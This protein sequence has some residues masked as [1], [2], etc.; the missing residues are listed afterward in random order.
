MKN[1]YRST[2]AAF[3]LA[4]LLICGGC[5][6]S[7]TT[8]TGTAPTPAP[9]TVANAISLLATADQAAVTTAITARDAG[10]ISAADCGAIENV[11]VKIANAGLAMNAELR[12]ADSWSVQKQKLLTILQATGLQ[13]L[14][15]HIS[16]GAYLVVVDLITAFN[17][18]S[19]ALGGPQI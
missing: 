14:R 15:A 13:E 18:T 8:A 1:I 17:Q 4:L 12:T 16:A 5:A 10:K 2:F 7:T 6:K 3:A 19:V 11:S 9:V